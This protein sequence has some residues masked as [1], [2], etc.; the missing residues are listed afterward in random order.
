VGVIELDCE[1]VEL[2]ECAVVVG[3]LPRPAEPRL[4]RLAVAL[5]E[6]VEHVSLLVPIMAT[7]P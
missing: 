7:S 1:R 4:D 6:V 2:L 5:G 3:L